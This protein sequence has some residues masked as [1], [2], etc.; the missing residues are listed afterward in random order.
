MLTAVEPFGPEPARLVRH[1]GD[2][3][4]WGSSVSIEGVRGP[5][6]VGDG[7]STLEV[8]MLSGDVIRIEVGTCGLC[9]EP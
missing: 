6:P 5:W 8:E 4:N 9:A 7:V 3:M 2:E 1:A